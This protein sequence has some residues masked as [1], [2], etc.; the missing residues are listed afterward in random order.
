M[1]KINNPPNGPIKGRNFTFSFIISNRGVLRKYF[2][3]KKT[4]GILVFLLYPWKFQTRQSFTYLWEL[5]KIVLR[6]KPGTLEIPNN[7]F[8][9][10][11]GNSQLFLINPWKFHFPLPQYPLEIPYSHPPPPC[12]TQ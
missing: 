9:I 10:T 11:P 2:L 3:R 6:P 7:L 4:L 1:S 12:K 8:L 5:H